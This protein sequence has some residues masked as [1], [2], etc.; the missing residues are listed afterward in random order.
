MP[1]TVDTLNIEITASAQTAN[2]AI[3]NLVQKLTVLKG[4]LNMGNTAGV[5]ALTQ[6]IKQLGQAMQVMSGYKMPDFNRVAKG[7]ERLG[8]VNVGN[9]NGVASSL[10]QF[11]SSLNSLSTMSTGA[12]QLASLVSS[13][14]KLGN[15][16]IYT[17]INNIPK[18]A[19]A[20]TGLMATLSKAPKVSRNVIDLA[21]AMA[22]LSKSGAKLPTVT[23]NTAK[24][25][26]LFSVAAKKA[27][28]SSSGLAVTIGKIYASY[29]LLFRLFSKLAKAMSISSQITELQNVINMT[30]GKSQDKINDFLNDSVQQFG[31]SELAVKKYA[32]RFQAL[33]TAM[34]ISSKSIEKANGFLQNKTVSGYVNLSDDMGDVSLT[35]TKLTA[36]IASFYDV[37]QS[38]VA[39]DLQAIFTGMT[40]P[41]RKYGLDL[42]QATLKEWALRN[43]LNADIKSMSQAEKTMLRYQYVL[44]NTTQL[45]GDFERTSGTWHNQVTILKAGFEQ[46]AN[47]VGTILINAF[48]GLLKSVNQAMTGI[49][50][51]MNNVLNAL[52]EIFGWTVEVNFG[53]LTNDT[54]DYAD[55][56]EDASDSSKKLKNNLLGIDELN[57]INDKNSDS[58]SGSSSSAVDGANKIISVVDTGEKKYES[59]IKNLEQLGDAIGNKLTNLMNGI[60]WDSV[61]QGARDFGKGLADFLNG[62]ISPE[63]F[64]AVGRTIANSLNAAIQ[65]SLTFATTFDWE[66]FGLSIAEGVNEFFR[67]FNFADLADDIDAWVQGIWKTVKTAVTNIDWSDVF[68]GAKDFFKELDIE[69]VELV[70]GYLMIRN[71]A[72][73]AFGGEA[74][75]LAGR[76]IATRLGAA[77]SAFWFGTIVPRLMPAIAA[78]FSGIKP[79]EAFTSAFGKI[80]TMFMGIASA[81]GGAYLSVSNFLDMWNSGFSWANELLM[82]LGIS[83]TAVGAILLGAPAVVAGV[84]AGIIAAV[85]TIAVFI[86]D[87]WDEVYGYVTYHLQDIQA[88]INGFVAKTREKLL[89]LF[90]PVRKK[91]QEFGDWV[92][93]IFAPLTELTFGDMFDAISNLAKGCANGIIGFFESA[94]N[95][96]IDGIN[97]FFGMLNNGISFVN[98][99]THQSF[100]AI[101]LINHI[102][103][104][105]F[106][107]GG[108][109]EIGSLFIAGEA[110]AEMVGNINGKTGVASGEE[111]TGIREAINYGTE[112]EASLL[113]QAV[114]L[115]NEIA[116]KD[117]SIELDGRELVDAI[118]KRSSRNGFAFS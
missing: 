58:G 103:L 26:N 49:I 118:N 93:N 55:A 76:Q 116:N 108:Y 18:L 117:T 38:D 45:Q 6:S 113:A 61:F 79:S 62:L 83:L 100:G 30:F 33:G 5:F 54:E 22:S 65:A 105:K 43:G 8:T 110:G 1:G 13:F 32:A 2:R 96:I 111:I 88:R 51:A 15:K 19:S 12:Q 36:D 9:I 87:N 115:L 16:S 48:K 4:A 50:S 97:G 17:A 44:A 114:T 28:T 106:A 80:P 104:P 56:L 7:I 47:I 112:T 84:A 57:V 40:K 14:A 66:N 31:M 39:E 52:G 27:K 20:F 70:I 42:T 53:G 71:I 11:A 34:A 73:I 102:S 69:T 98:E 92:K 109:P 21:N 41:L 46:L 37:A 101:S 91:L 78:S 99:V 82:L 67:T 64:G 72:K 94:V 77:V 35:L 107:N 68:S 29:W 3:E 81:A 86:H 24:G 23:T 89:A 75:A 10:G 60:D 95:G 85:G 59:W 74:I 25:L 90:D 63:L